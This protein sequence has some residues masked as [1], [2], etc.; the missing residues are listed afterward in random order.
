MKTKL[1]FFIFGLSAAAV[2]AAGTFLSLVY[3]QDNQ[4]P[5]VRE[6]V[7]APGKTIKIL[8]FL[9]AWGMDHSQRLPEQDSFSLDYVSAA[10]ETDTESINKEALQVFELIRPV[11]EQWGFN[12]ATVS[13]FRS[14]SR[15][16]QYYI[17][18]FKRA[19]NGSWSFERS[20]QG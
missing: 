7:L 11:S 20:T 3:F 13:A 5:I 9:L 8:S 2:L 6:Q 16:G 15:N 1:L 17:F 4:S 12:M 10:I 14:T 18:A 19:E